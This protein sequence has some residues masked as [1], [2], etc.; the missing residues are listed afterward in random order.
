MSDMTP[1][2]FRAEAARCHLE[3]ET[4]EAEGNPL[5]AVLFRQ[6]ERGHLTLAEAQEALNRSP[7]SN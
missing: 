5:R 7:Q 4:A 2:Q 3:A 6:L 1:A